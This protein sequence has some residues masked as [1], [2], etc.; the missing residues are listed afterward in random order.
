MGLQVLTLQLGSSL[1]GTEALT[2]APW[3]MHVIEF[4]TTRL[5]IIMFLT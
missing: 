2:I 1:V 5:Y 3:P 4:E